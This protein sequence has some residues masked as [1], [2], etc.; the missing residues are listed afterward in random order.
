MDDLYRVKNE[1]IELRRKIEQTDRGLTKAH[2][3]LL[4]LNNT[5]KNNYTINYSSA[6]GSSI[7]LYNNDVVR[8]INFIR[9]TLLPAIEDELNDINSRISQG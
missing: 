3:S 4:S 5:I 9:L 1:Y 8:L 7:I 2:E 6:A